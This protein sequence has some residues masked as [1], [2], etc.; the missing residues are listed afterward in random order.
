MSCLLYSLCVQWWT[1]RTPTLRTR[2]CRLLWSTGSS[3]RTRTE[4]ARRT[5]TPRSWRPSHVSL[6]ILSPADLAPSCI[7]FQGHFQKHFHVSSPS[8]PNYQRSS[9]SVVQASCCSFPTIK[10]LLVSELLSLDFIYY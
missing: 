10:L 2:S 1:S 6:D 8:R 7:S 9:Q 5:R 3:A 4:R